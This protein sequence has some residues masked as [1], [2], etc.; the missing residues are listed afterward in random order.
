LK[1]REIIRIMN[2]WAPPSL[3][4]NWDNT[5]FQIG[6]DKKEVKKILIA[7]DLDQGVYERASL[8]D[9]QMIISHHPVIFKPLKSVTTEGHREKLIYNIIKDDIV[10]FNAHTNLDRAENGL[11]DHLA[12]L[13]GLKKPEI[14]ELDQEGNEVV[15]GYGRVG[16]IE[17]VALLDYLSLIKKELDTDYLTVYGEFERRIKRVA[18]CGGSGSDFIP[19]AY[20]KGACI[21]I[22]G[23]IKYHDAQLGTEMGLTIVDAGHYHTEKIILPV[24]KRYLEENLGEDLYIEIWDKPS[25]EYKIY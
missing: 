7:L 12:R 4:D 18:V 20:K 17:E 22:T 24:I 19:H 23:D 13:L 9:F 5:G 1:A 14:L 11:N 2:N 8:G 3:I 16:D 10:V 6:N 25:P 21:Y 15:N